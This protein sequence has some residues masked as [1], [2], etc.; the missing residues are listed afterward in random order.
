[1]VRVWTLGNN[2]VGSQTFPYI[3]RNITKDGSPVEVKSPG[4]LKELCK[5]HGVIPRP[6]NGW[7]ETE[8]KGYQ[9]GGLDPRTHEYKKGKQ[10]YREG[11]GRGLPGSWI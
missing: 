3:T 10:V 7:K 2:D 4:H 9:P 5:R 8:Y 6:D 11:S 1:M